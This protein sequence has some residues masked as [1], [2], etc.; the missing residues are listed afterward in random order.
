[1]PKKLL[2]SKLEVSQ[3]EY[4]NMALQDTKLHKLN[5]FIL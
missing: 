4:K 1:M 3:N 2:A 5:V